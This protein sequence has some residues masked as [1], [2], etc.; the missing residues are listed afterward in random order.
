MESDCIARNRMGESAGLTL[1][2][3]GGDG[4]FTGNC[5]DAAWMA[6]CTSSAAPSI[7]RS[8]SNWMVTEVVPD[9]LCDVMEETPAMVENCDS[10][11]VATALAMVWGSAPGRLAE[12]EMVGK[13]TAGNSL[14]GKS[15]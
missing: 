6:A 9:E 10:S 13:S 1:R 11:G 15:A 4:M 14:T 7:S 5:R 12:T 2:K 8:R 3:V